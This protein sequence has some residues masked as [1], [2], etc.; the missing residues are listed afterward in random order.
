L[1]HFWEPAVTDTELLISWAIKASVWDRR[2]A[3]AID[4]GDRIEAEAEARTSRRLVRQTSD[5]VAS[6][7]RARQAR[8][9]AAMRESDRLRGG[10]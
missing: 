3:I 1:A 8:I 9:A 5:A 2:A 7:I 4:E 10:L 6:E